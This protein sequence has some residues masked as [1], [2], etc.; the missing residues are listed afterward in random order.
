MIRETF[1]DPDAFQARVTEL[2]EKF[3]RASTVYM[4]RGV[5]RVVWRRRAVVEYHF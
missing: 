3:G 1:Y 2:E 4:L 5:T